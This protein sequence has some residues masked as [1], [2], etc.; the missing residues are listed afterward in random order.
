MAE[1]RESL[2]PGRISRIA[3]DE[4]GDVL[5][6]IGGIETYY[7]NA[8]ELH[9]LIVRR[10]RERQG[11]GRRLV[12]DFEKQVAQGGGHTVWLGTDDENFRTTLGGVDL[13]PGVLDKFGRIRLNFFLKFYQIVGV[14]P[15]AKGFGKPDILMA[16]RI[17]SHDAS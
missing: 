17:V 1:V 15:D 14:V 9:P 7:G 10:D 5:G 12:A 6:W 16:K 3:V 11:L 4:R 2:Q 13:Y 8:W